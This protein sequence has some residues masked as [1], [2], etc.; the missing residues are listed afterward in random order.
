MQEEAEELL[1]IRWASRRT[2]A[3]RAPAELPCPPVNSDE[4]RLL[5]CVL[6]NLSLVGRIEFDL[7]DERRPESAVFQKIAST[8]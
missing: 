6:A 7:L 2:Y 1:G 8:S 5:R 3:R 4:Q